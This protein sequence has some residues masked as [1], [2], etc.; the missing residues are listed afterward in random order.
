MF[1]QYKS[2]QLGWR[3][4]WEI[5]LASIWLLLIRLLKPGYYKLHFYKCYLHNIYHGTTL[6]SRKWR[7]QSWILSSSLMK[8]PKN[9]LSIYG[10]CILYCDV[11]PRVTPTC[12]GAV[13]EG[14]PV[15]ERCVCVSVW[16]MQMQCYH[17]EES[18]LD[19][20]CSSPKFIV[21]CTAN[22]Q[23]ACQKEVIHGQ[24]GRPRNRHMHTIHAQPTSIKASLQDNKKE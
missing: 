10:V 13:W 2:S 14:I 21:N 8:T 24:D 15:C 7:F 4:L 6:Q 23:N 16:P 19:N 11:G 17:C 9:P 22:I 12:L 1:S 5:L 3:V 20:D 18:L